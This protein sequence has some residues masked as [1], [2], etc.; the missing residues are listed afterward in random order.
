M[1]WGRMNEERDENGELTD[2]A[3][4]LDAISDVG[5]DCGTD[6]PGS[7]FAC[8]CEAALK[9]LHARISELESALAEI[10]DRSND[11][12]VLAS[13]AI[14]ARNRAEVALAEREREIADLSVGIS[15]QDS[16]LTAKYNAQLARCGR[17]ESSL[18]T[19]TAERDAEVRRA[20]TAEA[21]CERLRGERA[22][23]HENAQKWREA[24]SEPA[25]E[26]D[27]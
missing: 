13:Q 3:L 5:C 10:K 8:L 23:I 14:D 1:E 17:L 11:N 18:S 22:E 16:V 20:R 2:L 6:E 27:K 24:C 4:A 9:S 19:L 26:D 25:G 15:A 21:E 12:A 7:C